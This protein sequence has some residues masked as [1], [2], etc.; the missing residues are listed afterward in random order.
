MPF[1]V[2][3]LN[4]SVRWMRKNAQIALN[5]VHPQHETSIKQRDNI[6]NRSLVILILCKYIL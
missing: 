6:A 1:E 5:I 2:L 4:H 3:L